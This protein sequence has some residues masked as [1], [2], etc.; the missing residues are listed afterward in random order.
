M[1]DTNF[2]V[3]FLFPPWWFVPLCRPS[4]KTPPAWQ[5]CVLASS[6]RLSRLKDFHQP[7]MNMLH[8]ML[9]CVLPLPASHFICYSFSSLQVCIWSSFLCSLRNRICVPRTEKMQ[10]T[11]SETRKHTQSMIQT[12][13]STVHRLLIQELLCPHPFTAAGSKLISTKYVSSTVSPNY[14]CGDKFPKEHLGRRNASVCVELPISWVSICPFIIRRLLALKFETISRQTCLDSNRKSLFS[15]GSATNAE[16]LQTFH[17]FW[18]KVQS[19]MFS[20]GNQWGG[21]LPL[22]PTM[23]H[24]YL[25][26]PAAVVAEL[27]CDRSEMVTDHDSSYIHKCVT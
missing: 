10:K 2:T 17:E 6:W 5:V 3:V 9:C 16:Q 11:I 4:C 14:R 8:L 1:L 23:P 26:I 20:H 18:F 24:Y 27:H 13:I 22:S 25:W 19:S 12:S 21:R 15:V 7:V